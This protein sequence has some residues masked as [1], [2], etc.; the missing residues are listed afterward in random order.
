VDVLR[1][2]LQAYEYTYTK[3]GRF[4]YSA[5]P[6]QHDDTVVSLALAY[7]AALNRPPYIVDTNYDD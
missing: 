7:E 3:G 6:G 1:E 5:P 4:R 2:E